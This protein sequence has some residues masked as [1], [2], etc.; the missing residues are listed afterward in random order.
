MHFQNYRLRKTWL[1]KNQKSPVSE[2]PSKVNIL[3][4]NLHGS[5][6]VRFFHISYPK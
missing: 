4:G 3:N 5:M 1:D 6:F 2:H